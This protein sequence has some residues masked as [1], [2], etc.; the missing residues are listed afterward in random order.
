[1]VAARKLIKMGCEQCPK[2]EDV[3]LEAARLHVSQYVFV[4]WSLDDIPNHRSSQNNDDAKV[5]LANAVQH[6]GQSVKIWL[7]AKDLEH[8]EKAKRRVLR[9]GPYSTALLLSIYGVVLT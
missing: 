5:I 8:D 3:W 1:M 7:A 4:F 6:V 2:S 9:K